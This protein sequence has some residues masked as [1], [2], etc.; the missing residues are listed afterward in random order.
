MPPQTNAQKEEDMKSKNNTVAHRRLGEFDCDLGIF[1]EFIDSPEGQ[2][3]FILATYCESRIKYLKTRLAGGFGPILQED[4]KKVMCSE[5]CVRSDELH[6]KALSKSRCT[7]AQ[8]SEETFVKH[9]FCLENSARMLCTH[10]SECGHWDCAL[11]DFMC[12]R[13][14]W[15]RLY[16][17]AAFGLDANAMLA[18]LCVFLLQLMLL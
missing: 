7:C 4:L 15:D 18:M 16:A 8:A 6:Q 11:E 13:Y 5:E 10:L 17:C 9:E 12:Q 1:D 2:D 3:I 14:E